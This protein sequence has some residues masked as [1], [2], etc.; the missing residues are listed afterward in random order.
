M[1]RPPVSAEVAALL[2]RLASE[3][4]RWGYKRIQGG[5]LKAGHWVSAPA[6]RRSVKTLKIP[7]APRL[8]SE[9]ESR[10]SITIQL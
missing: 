6:I 1:G 5:L 4:K 3:N 8:D 2:E 9:G 10:H 7:P